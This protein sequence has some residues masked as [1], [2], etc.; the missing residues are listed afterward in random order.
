MYSTCTC[1]LCTLVSAWVVDWPDDGSVQV[2]WLGYTLL[3]LMV[4]RMTVYNQEVVMFGTLRR[5]EGVGQSM[6]HPLIDME[7]VLRVFEEGSERE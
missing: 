6:I 4:V 1:E 5:V 7:E 3:H 2:H